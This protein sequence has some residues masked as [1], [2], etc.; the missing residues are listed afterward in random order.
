MDADSLKDI[1][2]NSRT[3]RQMLDWVSPIYDNS[4]VGLWMFEAIGREYDKLWAIVDSLP[5]QLFPQTVTWAIEL[6]ERR[7]GI[8]PIP[9]Q[10]LASRR[11][12][13]IYRQINHPPMSPYRLETIILSMT[14]YPCYVE[15]WVSPYTFGIK[16]TARTKELSKQVLREIRRL[17]P[18][19]LSYEIENFFWA[20][21]TITLSTAMPTTLISHHAT[22]VVP[23]LFM[24][25][26][27]ITTTANMATLASSN[28][29]VARKPVDIT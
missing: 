3:G 28:R 9:G 24:R 19:H 17:K 2:L 23:Q 21:H 15:D 7:Y 18:S 8:T 12:A 27:T 29:A 1:I 11:A 13:I 25:R 4:Y 10:N 22:I 20:K 14:G 16:F 5:D 6:W 26:N